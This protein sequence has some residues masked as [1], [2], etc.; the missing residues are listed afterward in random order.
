MFFQSRK[1]FGSGRPVVSL[2][3]VWPG[4]H[5]QGTEDRLPPNRAEPPA[6]PLEREEAARFEQRVQAESRFAGDVRERGDQGDARDA[7]EQL[8]DPAVQL[9]QEPAEVLRV[10]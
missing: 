9:A 3:Q 4:D 6:S 2:S 7:F 5:G 1:Y 8:V 10:P